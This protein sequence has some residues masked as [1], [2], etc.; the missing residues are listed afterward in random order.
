M[1]ATDEALK[2]WNALKPMIV[3]LIEAKTRS[4]VR[5]KKMTVTTAPDNG[6]VGVTA[7]YDREVEVPIASGVSDAEKGDAVWAYWFMNNASTLHV[8]EKG[9]GGSGGGSG[10]A[11][12]SLG[13][14]SASGGQ[15]TIPYTTADGGSGSVNFNIADTQFYMDGVAAAYSAGWAAAKAAISLSGNVISGPSDTADVPEPLFTITAEGEITTP[16]YNSAANYFSAAVRNWAAVN[17]EYVS[18]RMT[19]MQSYINVG[20]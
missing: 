15:I 1:S 4:C 19:T 20:Q 17:G 11:I 12:V 7:P 8:T 14:A 2:I 13:P 6:V 18:S 9:G 3:S 16:I 10:S 5:A